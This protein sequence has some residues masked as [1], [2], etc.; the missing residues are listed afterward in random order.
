MPCRCLR[1]SV[2]S[3][4][5]G[6]HVPGDSG[7]LVL[8][9]RWQVK[10]PFLWFYSCARSSLI[11][12]DFLCADCTVCASHKLCKCDSWKQSKA[13]DWEKGV[14]ALHDSVIMNQRLE[15]LTLKIV[16]NSAL[17]SPIQLILSPCSSVKCGDG[18]VDDKCVR[19][20]PLWS[21]LVHHTLP[22]GFQQWR[23]TWYHCHQCGGDLQDQVPPQLAHH[24]LRGNQRHL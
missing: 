8:Q 3:R 1:D 15:F 19:R 22:H 18:G 12:W 24:C 6:N 23:G 7:E 11:R 20:K 13:L 4:I 5:V 16:I 9:Q 17:F 10:P 2:I 14:I 21:L